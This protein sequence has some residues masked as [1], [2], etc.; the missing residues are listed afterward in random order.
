MTAFDLRRAQWFNRPKHFSLEEGKAAIITDPGTV[1]WQRTYYGFRNDNAHVLYVPVEERFFSFRFQVSFAY[2]VLY[3]QCGLAIYQDSEN[4]V[5]AGIE[6]HD[7][8]TMWLGSVVTN[9]GY[10]DWATTDIDSA[11]RSIWY[12]LSRRESDFRIEHSP[13]GLSWKQM[14][15]FHF[16]KGG[17]GV[18]LGLL[19]C[20]PG[21]SSFTAVFTGM[22]ISDCVWEKEG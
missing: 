17:G 4:W 1:F 11:V 14:R 18:N 16:T 13:D 21:N 9:G 10:S 6:F 22:D 2:S 7:H 5:K 20:S 12:R 19:A 8:N 3:D 15:I